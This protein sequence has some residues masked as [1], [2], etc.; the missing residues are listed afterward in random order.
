MALSRGRAGLVTDVWLPE[1]DDGDQAA[2]P[3]H[4]HRG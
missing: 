1:P 4:D 2:D 3:G